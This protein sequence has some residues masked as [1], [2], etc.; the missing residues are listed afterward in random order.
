MEGKYGS[1]MKHNQN[2]NNDD[3]AWWYITYQAL[4]VN[5]FRILVLATQIG[6]P[7][8]SA[9]QKMISATS[10]Y[11]DTPALLALSKPTT[12]SFTRWG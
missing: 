8:I 10:K 9:I 11:A 4:S 7:E 12:L 6:N 1:M 3:I 2:G 5:P